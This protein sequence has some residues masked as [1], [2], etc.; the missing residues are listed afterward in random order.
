M[1]PRI[2]YAAPMPLHEV[3]AASRT[4][5]LTRWKADVRGTLAPESTPTVELL[6]HMPQFLDEIIAALREDTGMGETEPL[7]EGRTTAAVHGEQ[8]LRLGF[9]LDAVVREYG[10]LRD[11]I[12]ASARAA[13]AEITF[14]ELKVV[15]DCI[16]S[17]IANA[18]SEYTMQ[19]DA[20]LHRQANEHFAF[21]AHELRNPLSAAIS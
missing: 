17:G 3:L 20:E 16:I 12:V 2:D 18:V 15:S 5:V 6:D 21:I 9:Q 13:S 10:A 7:L 4:E 11:A 1:L 19:R 14:R 8:R